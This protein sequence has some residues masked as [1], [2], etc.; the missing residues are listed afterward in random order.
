MALPRIKSILTA[1]LLTAALS[2]S[3]PTKGAAQQNQSSPPQLSDDTSDTLSTSFHPAYE[4]G[5]WEKSISILNGILPKVPADSYDAEWVYGTEGTIYIQNLNK[6]ALALASFEHALAIDDR[7]HFFDKKQVQQVLFEVS[8]IS[9]QQAV[10]AKD[11]NAKQ[12]LFDNAVATLDRWLKNADNASLTQEKCQYIATVYF[13]I[14]QGGSELGSAHKEDKAMLTKALYWIDRG[15]QSVIRPNDTLIQMYALKVAALYQLGRYPEMADC[16]EFELK[17]KPNNK[18]NWIQLAVIYQQLADLATS[19]KDP[20][21][22]FNY[23]VREILTF[24]RA[25]ALG[26]M[27]TPEDNLNIV[28]LFSTINQYSKACELLESGMKNGTIE[29][30]PDNWEMLGTWYQQIDRNDQAVKAFTTATELFPTNPKL[31]Y[32]LAQVYLGIPNEKEAFEH[33]KACI[34]KGNLPQAHVGWL[35]YTYA[36]IN[37]QKFDDALKGAHEA[38]EAAR[39]AGATESVKQ[40]QTMIATINANIQDIKSR[41]QEHR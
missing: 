12:A 31:E 16:L 20:Q 17:Y 28:K 24:Q 32:E 11:I 34:A 37:L 38:E 22:A 3:I 35:F 9:Y 19:K 23:T 7:K 5:N 14:G 6:P 26:F 36:A 33:I 40:A 4:A 30:T 27:N 1:L 29:S 21:T 13:F 41:N 8:Q 39:K 18:N 10:A 2:A 15:M 25:Q